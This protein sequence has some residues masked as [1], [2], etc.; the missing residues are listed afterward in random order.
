MGHSRTA[1]RRYAGAGAISTAAWLLLFIVPL[2]YST[3][4]EGVIVV[5]EQAEVRAR[6]E[7]FVTKVLA[8]SGKA[9]TAG[10][11]LVAL[12]DP[13]LDARVAVTTAQ[14]EEIRQ[15]LDAVRQVDRVQAEM[16]EDQA[17]HLAHPILF[18]R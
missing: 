14:L 9:V 1:M 15:R 10:E 8:A 17:S 2:P 5:P 18:R 3:V 4:A 13:T 7:G 6:T 11:P 12:E 16:F